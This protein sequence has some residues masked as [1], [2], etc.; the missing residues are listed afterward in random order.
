[1]TTREQQKWDVLSVSRSKRTEKFLKA[2]YEVSR[3]LVVLENVMQWQ[4]KI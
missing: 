4:A 1:M 2:Q 3:R